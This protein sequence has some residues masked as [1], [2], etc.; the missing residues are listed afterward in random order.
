MHRY[1][2]RLL[3]GTTLTFER[4]TR[5]LLVRFSPSLAFLPRF[6]RNNLIVSAR[7]TRVHRLRL[8]T[9]FFLLDRR[10]ATASRLVAVFLA[11]ATTRSRNTQ[12]DR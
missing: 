1:T 8:I 10:C 4:Q 5:F 9:N 3:T 11:Q 2:R 12:I 7:T 6:F